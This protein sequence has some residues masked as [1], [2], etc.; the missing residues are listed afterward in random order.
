[1]S[2]HI[3]NVLIREAQWACRQ[4]SERQRLKGHERQD[5]PGVAGGVDAESQEQIQAC[6]QFVRRWVFCGFHWN[7]PAYGISRLLGGARNSDHDHGGIFLMEVLNDFGD[8]R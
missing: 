5:K 8:K 6:L 4:R 1:M 3:V 7:I 2:Q